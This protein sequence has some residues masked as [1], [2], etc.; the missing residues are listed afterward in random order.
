MPEIWKLGITD[1]EYL[2]RIAQ[3]RGPSSR[4]YL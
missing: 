3:G 4:I 2:Q 1:E